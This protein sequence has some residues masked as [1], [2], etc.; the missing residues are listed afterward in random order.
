MRVAGS[1]RCRGRNVRSGLG[2]GVAAL[3]FLS[4]MVQALGAAF[5]S[6]AAPPTP[7]LAAV[8]KSRDVSHPHFFGGYQGYWMFGSDGRVYPYGPG[9]PPFQGDLGGKTLNAPIVGGAGY[10]N[11]GY[12]EVGSDGGVFKLGPAPFDGSAG[13]LHLN[14]P[15]VGMAAPPDSDGYWLVASDGGIF[16]YGGAGVFGSGAG[17]PQ[18]GRGVDAPLR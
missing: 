6:G 8:A 14:K 3:V 2:P 11:T 7:S 4:P 13:S 10:G 1:K 5:A 17:A 15:I 12:Y 9:V 16:N 18:A